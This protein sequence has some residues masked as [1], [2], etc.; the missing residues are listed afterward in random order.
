MLGKKASLVHKYLANESEIGGATRRDEEEVEAIKRQRFSCSSIH[1]M[2][3]RNFYCF[4]TG[5][6]DDD[7]MLKE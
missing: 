5:S 7:V 2:S 1:V 3:F 4:F 6:C